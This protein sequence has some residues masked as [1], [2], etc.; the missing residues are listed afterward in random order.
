M[1][2]APEATVSEPTAALTDK[3]GGPSAAEV[4][5]RLKQP[6]MA[7]VKAVISWRGVVLNGEVCLVDLALATSSSSRK[8]RVA[9]AGR[10]ASAWTSCASCS[11]SWPRGR[12]RGGGRG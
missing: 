5:A 4:A 10:A 11:K 8:S 7:E 3:Y 12:R 9:A 2:Q 1:P 6:D